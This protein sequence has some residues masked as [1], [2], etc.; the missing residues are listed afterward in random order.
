VDASGYIIP[1]FLSI[2][3]TDR[4][5]RIVI[6]AK[7]HDPYSKDLTIAPE[8]LLFLA[9]LKDS[10]W[11]V[12]RA[13]GY[14]D[15][16]T[17]LD[18][19]F[20]QF[21]AFFVSP[22]VLAT[23]RHNLYHEEGGVNLGILPLFSFGTF[24]NTE[25]DEYHPIDVIYEPDE[26]LER[27]TLKHLPKYDFAF[28][29]VKTPTYQHETFIQPAYTPLKIDD[30]ISTIQFNL[31]VD[32]DW[33]NL[34]KLHARQLTLTPDQINRYMHDS[35]QSTSPGKVMSI[36]P[37]TV[38]YGNSTAK[39]A[40]GAPGFSVASK[41]GFCLIHSGGTTQEPHNRGM[42]VDNDV[43]RKAYDTHV[44]PTIPTAAPPK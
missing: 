12:V 7:L 5:S 37:P 4:A 41:N 24:A 38:R 26:K 25:A 21:T 23:A 43:F 9:N 28:L 33:V 16:K 42:L 22:T 10:N 19:P 40:S 6:P 29:R 39:G 34:Q 20:V 1:C 11:A 30:V 13:F 18:D 27:E 14:K 8:I 15:S 2:P 36:D 17:P 32:D 35:R 31:I 44:V 3:C